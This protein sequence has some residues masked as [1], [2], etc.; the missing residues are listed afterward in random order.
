MA[1]KILVAD[2][3]KFMRRLLRRMLAE[4]GY[5]D[6]IEAADGEQAI[7]LY[8]AERPDLVLLDITMPG[9]PGMEVL[10]DLRSLDPA[11]KIVMCSA[12]G[13]ETV[14]AQAK[15]QGACGFLRKPFV[16]SELINAV[17]QAILP[18]ADT[19]NR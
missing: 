19:Q 12:V 13:Q 2:D 7:A 5:Y 17:G 15:Q 4:G 16:Q 10:S 9:K 8:R 14:A 11:A 3:A 6:I 18:Q 1:A